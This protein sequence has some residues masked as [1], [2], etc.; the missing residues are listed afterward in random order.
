MFGHVDAVIS[1]SFQYTFVENAR[2]GEYHNE[3]IWE[4][5]AK[6]ADC[7]VQ[8]LIVDC[9]VDFGHD[10]EPLA[11]VNI[12]LRCIVPDQIDVVL[13]FKHVSTVIDGISVSHTW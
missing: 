3:T 12:I 7:H 4:S 11:A 10:P 13:A 9:T 8:G 1:Q 6:L 2:F 5:A